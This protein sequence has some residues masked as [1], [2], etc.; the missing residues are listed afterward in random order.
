MGIIIRKQRFSL[1]PTMRTQEDPA[2][3]NPFSLSLSPQDP[4]CARVYRREKQL[5]HPD[6]GEA[7]RHLAPPHYEHRNSC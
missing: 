2:L 5:H 7:Y 1:E 3:K 6:P 4:R